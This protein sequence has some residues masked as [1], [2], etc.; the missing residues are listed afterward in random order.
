MDEYA[1][2]DIYNMNKTTLYW[3][4]IPDVTLATE[5]QNN[6]KKEKT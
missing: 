6:I 3:K 2:K 4:M 1:I 5:R